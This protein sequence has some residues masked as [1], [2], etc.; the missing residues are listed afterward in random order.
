MKKVKAKEC[1]V[2]GLAGLV[3]LIIHEKIMLN[4]KCQVCASNFRQVWDVECC[5]IKELR[6]LQTKSQNIIMKHAKNDSKL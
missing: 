4:S 1:Y 2:H 5:G 3:N 6:H